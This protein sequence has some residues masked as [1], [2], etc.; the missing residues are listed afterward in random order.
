MRDYPD[1]KAAIIPTFQFGAPLNIMNTVGGPIFFFFYDGAQPPKDVFAD[2]DAINATMDGTGTKSYWELS[3]EAGGAAPLPGFG[4][5]FRENTY[6]NMPPDEMADFYEVVWE[7]TSKQSFAD[8]IA[9]DVQIMGFDPQPVSVRIAKASNAQGGNALGLDPDHGDRI[10]IENNLLWLNDT[11]NENCP[12]YS[13]KVSQ[14]IH[15]YHV[16][17]YSG[18]E[19]TNYRSGNTS[20]IK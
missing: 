14:A 4:A 5:S 6:P 2:F 8:S 20:F 9:P 16:Q 1:A 13:K 15:D 19:P 17:T 7:K 10:W 12:T 3:Q 18:V 11:C